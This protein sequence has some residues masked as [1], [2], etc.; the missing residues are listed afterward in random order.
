[1]VQLTRVS[2]DP[3][4]G[5]AHTQHTVYPVP[6]LLIGDTN[7]TKVQL[8]IGRGLSDIAPTVLDLLGLSKPVRMTGR[9]LILKNSLG[10]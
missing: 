1:M 7:K 10:I 9:S 6:F 8:G 3:L 2:P 5:E 4:T